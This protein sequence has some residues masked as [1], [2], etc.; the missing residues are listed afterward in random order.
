MTK[1]QMLEIVQAQ[2][3]AYNKRDIEGFAKCFHPE[4]KSFM[5]VSDKQTNDGITKFKIGYG[6]FFS[7]NPNLHCELKS[8]IVL[9]QVVIDEEFVTGAS[10]F[11]DGLHAI[12]IYAF[13][14]GLIDRIWFP[15]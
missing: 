1:Q 12:A 4:V 5:L 10:K 8:R 6:K 15:R 9:D 11:P 7:E 3:E 13:R 2:L 14:D